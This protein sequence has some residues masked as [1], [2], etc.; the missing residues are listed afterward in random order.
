MRFLW[1]CLPLLLAA[2]DVFAPVDD[3][4]D[5]SPVRINNASQFET[6]RSDDLA[7]GGT[8]QDSFSCEYNTCTRRDV[9]LVVENTGDIDVIGFRSATAP[10]ADEPAVVDC[11]AAPWELGP[12][13]STDVI[14][15]IVETGIVTN[16]DCDA[17]ERE[18]LLVQGPCGE[19][20]FRAGTTTGD[21]DGDAAFDVTFTFLLDDGATA[22]AS[23]RV[24][25]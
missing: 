15:V 19:G 2:C 10:G 7:C 14:D 12:G 1:P 25:P 9:S 16:D 21:F 23:F 11:R 13:D 8:E 4:E 22:D 17:V 20:G 18:A 5:E 24:Q 3:G 6:S